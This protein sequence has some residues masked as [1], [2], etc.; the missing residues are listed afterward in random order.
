MKFYFRTDELKELE[1]LRKQSAK[2]SRMAVLVGR[3]RVGKTS[4]ALEFVDNKPHVY[5]FV[6][7]KS[8]ALLCQSFIDEIQRQLKI[9][10]HGRVE[11]F[12]QIFELLIE[13]A[14]THKF[15][16]IVDEFQE[17]LKINPSI[18]SDLQGIWDK[19]KNTT[20]MMLIFIGS[21]Y[22]LMHNIFE[23]EKEP[24]FGRADRIIKI[25]PFTIAQ[26]QSLLADHGIN[27]L[28]RLF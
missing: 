14:R 20:E 17:F 8:E 13:H 21:I 27:D 23:N 3:R 15:V 7:R 2:T 4:L 25:K 9:T 16:V 11:T 22:S 18:Y 28:K 12:K 24:L 26:V 1:T 5:L 10:I 19:N 6:A